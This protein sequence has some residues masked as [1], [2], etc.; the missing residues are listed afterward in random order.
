MRKI[1]K[2][3]VEGIDSFFNEIN[4]KH[5]LDDELI[6]FLKRFIA[7]SEC[8]RIQFSGFNFPA[9][10]LSLETGVLINK[11]TLDGQLP[12]LVFVILHEIA[13]QYQFKKYG[14]KVMYECYVGNISDQEAADFM[15]K[16]EIVADEFATRKIRQLQK[17]GYFEGFNPPSVY[18]NMSMSQ[19]EMMV[20]QFRMM[21]RS[22]NITTPE[23]ISEFF[24]NITKTDL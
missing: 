9:L 3:E 4:Q 21:I 17:M 11:V 15:R 8:Q 23:K 1:I 18:K 10:G 20:K 12:M 24:Y 6:G 16:T 19:I 22:K 13:H 7:E 5:Q 14:S 2:E